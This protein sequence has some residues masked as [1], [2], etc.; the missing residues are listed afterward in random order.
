[1]TV[2]HVL[3]LPRRLIPAR[4]RASGA[5]S[6]DRRDRVGGDSDDD[7]DCGNNDY[8]DYYRAATVMW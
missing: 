3:V 7:G 8:A 2:K 5:G 1:M 6:E 4:W